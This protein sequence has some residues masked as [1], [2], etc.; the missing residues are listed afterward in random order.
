M[1]LL[2]RTFRAVLFDLDGTL[3]DST[4]ATTAAWTRWSDRIR[5]PVAPILAYAHGRPA[6][7]TIARFVRRRDIEAELAW[8]RAVELAER[9]PVTAV[10]GARA[11]LTRLS[12]PWGIVTSADDALARRRLSL[13]ALPVPG[14][15]ITSDRVARGKPAPDGYLEAA[16]CL[17]VPPPACLVF[18]DSPVGIEAAQ[19]AGMTVVALTTTTARAALEADSII[20]DYTGL[21]SAASA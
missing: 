6:R 19:R 15:L 12:V 11:L 4:R 21:V 7:S 1:Q 16:R 5:Q 2:G 20:D 13:A 8:H 9:S 3:V 17:G 18:E 10:D 14:V